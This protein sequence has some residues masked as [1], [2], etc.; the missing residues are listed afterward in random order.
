MCLHYLGN[1][2]TET[3]LVS[4]LWQCK[5]V[6]II[7]D[8]QKPSIFF[9]LFQSLSSNTYPF[10]THQQLRHI[11][12]NL[13]HQPIT[14]KLGDTH[15]QTFTSKCSRTS[16]PWYICCAKVVFPLQNVY[17]LW[18][19]DP[20]HA[21]SALYFQ[22]DDW[23]TLQYLES[24]PVT[25]LEPDVVIMPEIFCCMSCSCSAVCCIL[26]EPGGI[27]IPTLLN[28]NFGDSFVWF[29]CACYCHRYNHHH[30]Q[31]GRQRWER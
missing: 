17:P 9:N 29:L 15:A 8:N 13:L 27:H 26:L 6:H 21:F 12:S 7:Q 30:E 24:A 3:K 14:L 28:L 5:R 20:S 4:K 16:P 25:N 11:F 1:N 31:M 2:I 22:I 10:I 18:Q 19:S 23:M